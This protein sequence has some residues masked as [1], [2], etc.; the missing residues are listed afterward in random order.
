MNRRKKYRFLICALLFVSLA[1]LGFVSIEALKAQIPDTLFL[2]EGDAA[3]EVLP[4]PLSLLVEEHFVSEKG[5]GEGSSHAGSAVQQKE[6]KRINPESEAVLEADVLLQEKGNVPASSSRTVEYTL[7]GKIPL[8]TVSAQVADPPEVYAGGIPIGIYL[9][10]NGVLVVGTGE[11]RGLDGSLCCPADRIVKSGDYIK[12]VNGRVLSTKEDLVACVSQSAG[13]NLVLDIERDG[14]EIKLKISPVLDET[15]T[16][17]A[18]IWARND[19]QGIGTL[20]F[21]DEEGRFGALGHGISDIDTGERME[22]SGGTLY[23]AEV[24]SIVKGKQGIPGELA[25]LIHYN[26]GYKIGTIEEN[27]ANGIYGTVSGFP[28]LADQL[29]RYKVAYRQSVEKG[30]ASILCSIDGRTREYQVEIEEV[31]LNGSD[32][33]KGMILRVTDP[34]LLELTGGIVQGMSGSPIIQNGKLIGAVTH[35]FVQDS[36]KGYGIFIENMLG[37]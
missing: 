12:A 28:L 21:V 9:R 24:I 27:S 37:L 26:E 10:T 14:E 34:E 2:E 20:T 36:T 6:R 33:N 16:Y 13:A 1:G 8:K 30:P 17:R 15:G 29:Q 4:Y 11:I 22:I 7:F 25:G 19:T 32:I 31:R 5:D 23:S 3:P 18:G 35:V